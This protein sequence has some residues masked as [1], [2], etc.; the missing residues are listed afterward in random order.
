M[1]SSSERM[2]VVVPMAALLLLVACGEDQLRTVE[3]ATEVRVPAGA[4]AISSKGG[5]LLDTD[6]SEG[7]FCFQGQCTFEC[8][9]DADCAAGLCAGGRCV[10][11]QAGGDRVAR[12]RLD[13]ET[14]ALVATEQPVEVIE[15]PEGMVEV[16]PGEPFVSVRLRTAQ[17]VPDGAILYRVEF[18]GQEG[19][20]PRSFRAEGERDFVFHVPTGV[21]SGERGEARMQRVYLVT[22]VGG[23]QLQLVPRISV[24]GVY[25]GEIQVREFGGSGLP[26]RFGLRVEPEGASFEEAQERFLLLPSGVDELLAPVRSGADTPAW[27]ERPLEWDAQAEVWFARFAHPFALDGGSL[28]RRGMDQ[29][30]VRALRFEIS[31]VEGKRVIGA[32]ADRW[33]GLFD[34][35]TA[36]GVVAPG[37]VSLAGQ[38]IAERLHS[39]PAEAYQAVQGQ[40]QVDPPPVGQPLV[41]D[42]CGG[43]VFEDL[44][45]RAGAFAEENPCE[46]IRGVAELA[47]AT[48]HRRADCAIAMADEALAGPTTAAIVRAFLDET[49]PNP[50][51]LSF[52]AF[53]E[54][55]AA[56]DGYCVPSAEALCAE[57]VLAFAYQAQADELPQAGDLLDRF[58]TAAR[59][60][61][62][63][64]QLAAFQIDT[65]TRL[66]WLRKSEAPLFLAAHLRAYNEQILERWE[67]Q[68]LQAH[69]DVLGRQFAPSTLEVLGRAPT[70]PVAISARKQMLLEQAQSWQGAMEALQIAAERWNTLHQ[71]DLARAGAAQLVRT[72]SVDL[73]LSAAVLTHL[74]RSSGSSAT[75]SIFGS[76]FAALLRSLEQLSLPFDELVYMRD[77]EVVVSRSLDPKSDS[78]TLLGE[79]EEV[80]R[81]A[82]R[83]AQTSVDLVLADIHQSEVTQAVL[84][85]RMQ[86]Q[87]DELRSELVNL[88]GLPAG[89]S[90]ADMDVRPECRVQ[91]EVGRCGFM[92]G[93][94]SAMP[95]SFDILE[96]AE[97]ISSA[98][99]AVL[100][101]RQAMIDSHMAEEALRANEERARIEHENAEAFA[102]KITEWD[103]Q[104]RAVAAEVEQLIEEIFEIDDAAMS[105][106]LDALVEMQKLRQ[107]A[108][109]RQSAAVEQWDRM[110]HGGVDSWMSRMS[111][112]NGL[113]QSAGALSLAG[114]EIDRLAEAW[115]DGMPKAAGTAVDVGAP[116]RLAARMSAYGITTAMRGVA[117][118]LETAA[119]RVEQE[120]EEAQARREAELENLQDLAELDAQWTEVQLEGIAANL[121]AIELEAAD[122]IEQREAL[123]DALRRNLEL[124]LAHDRELVELRDRRDKV[125]IRLTES[126]SL[127]VAIL[128]QEIVAA[129]RL[130]DYLQVVQRAQLLQGR[131]LAMEERLQ[132]LDVLLA[133]P[134]TIFAHANRLARAESRVERAK[135]LLY[136]WLV[137]LE[138]YA[139]RPFVDQRLA[140]LLARNPSQLEAIA[141]EMVRLQRVCGGLVNYEVVDLSLRDD[142]LQVGFDAEVGE[143]GLPVEK[144]ERFRAVLQRG[145]VPIDTRVRYSSDERIGDLIASRQVLAA[146]FDLRLRDFANL[147]LTCNAKIAS[148][149]VRLVGEGLPESVRPTLSILYDGTSTLRS[150]QPD[151]DTIVGALGPGTTAFAEETRFR[152][153]GR[154]VSPI[155]HVGTFGAPDSAN[156]GLEGL[157]L[158][159]S[160]TLL[161]DPAAGENHRID[162]TK[163]EDVEL[164][165]TWG[166][167]DLFPEG[168]CR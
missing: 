66:E 164:R 122:E 10:H 61:Y 31:R 161:I 136:D 158:A 105:V 153:Q 45:A 98:G 78:N 141:D 55:C 4:I 165:L 154:S 29:R 139:V 11:L 33:Q 74:N 132:Q 69:F 41:I 97:N 135:D 151:I 58:Q 63:G 119:V 21:A 24:S 60:G 163:L 20:L 43:G 84:T 144:G 79:R 94:M 133:S 34:T 3:A 113:Q 54:R 42:A 111:A 35:R 156:R 27:V 167:Q 157:P 57:Q 104:R 76:G 145:N 118:A 12:P 102:R 68:V 114:D 168:Q 44:V 130:M 106:E 23:W 49:Q 127:R 15:P 36:D 125:R 22:S 123:I 110:R 6:C 159:S 138:Y 116:I 91:V 13:A 146:S 70:D 46:G 88:C 150:C 100:S 9:E 89:C 52:G 59:E 96:A 26:V 129:Q 30:V 131:Y 5:C 134:A 62:L 124:D 108:Y 140:L 56:G 101:Y 28:F 99:A 16:D 162:W 1:R 121:R 53:L 72:R 47:W 137:A 77:A 83:D 73:Y 166:Y 149:D 117:F 87:L 7:L 92:V 95:E 81:R 51:G 64:R 115:A 71:N 67:Q 38:L 90:P 148:V 48:D 50:D 86:T 112:I 142:L 152:V 143:S 32:A 109:D 18:E 120:M 19:E 65:D 25:A 40:A 128:R 82:V 17:P 160:Y 93:P 126:P 103:R 85:G 8:V 155:A 37:Q 80:A 75:S 2:R 14:I 147:P 107:E 39:L